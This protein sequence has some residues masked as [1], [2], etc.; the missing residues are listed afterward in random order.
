M[1]KRITERPRTL[2]TM[3]FVAVIGVAAAI[4]LILLEQSPTTPA[5]GDAKALPTSRSAPPAALAGEAATERV[6]VDVDST[7]AAT[8]QPAAAKSGIV[9]VRVRRDGGLAVPDCGVVLGRRAKG[10]TDADGQVDL[11]APPGDHLVAIDMSR[12]PVGLSA[13]LQ[14]STPP[15]YEV[16]NGFYPRR[17]HVVEGVVTEVE[18]RVFTTSSIT[19][20]VVDRAG[21]PMADLHV[22]AQCRKVGL[23]GYAVDAKTREDGVFLLDGVLPSV[24]TIEVH[25]VAGAS[26]LPLRLEVAE[27]TR[28][29]LD[30]IVVGGDASVTGKVKDQ[31]GAPVVGVPVVAYPRD[32]A[33]GADEIGFNLA[34]VLATARTDAD[35]NFRLEGLPG[36]TLNVQI[37]PEG[38]LVED[39][40]RLSRPIDVLTVDTRRERQADLGVVTA[41]VSRPFQLR[42]HIV[43]EETLTST[44]G[45]AASTVRERVF[46]VAEAEVGDETRWQPI[47][48]NGTCYPYRCET[49]SG[50]ICVI[51][52]RQ[53]SAD[54]ML[55]IEPKPLTTE[56]IDVVYP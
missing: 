46:V 41:D 17:V 36:A 8:A 29:L 6:P 9:R 11:S 20:M 53:G 5:A 48:W 26:A 38:C 25:P 44:I 2:L 14:D 37:H 16:T 56:D 50:P 39:G 30:P 22:R 23:T 54:R 34:N 7:G 10:T 55:R 13:A 47:W 42:I 51:V 33:S 45:D 52:R 49:P 15:H 32:G 21:L 27:A 24:Y 12:V 43:A 18:L 1:T 35:G 19:G 40:V 4:G 3:L 28:H 31:D